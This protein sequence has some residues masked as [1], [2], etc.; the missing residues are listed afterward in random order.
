MCINVVLYQMENRREDALKIHISFFQF[1]FS[2]R[3]THLSSLEQKEDEESF[4]R[5]GSLQGQ[6]DYE[7]HQVTRTESR[8]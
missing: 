1:S 3:P 7:K 8:D 6:G 5:Q 2:F 4:M